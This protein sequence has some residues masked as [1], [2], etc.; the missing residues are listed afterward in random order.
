[1]YKIINSGVDF[2]LDVICLDDYNFL[3][4]FK[5]E[6]R[7]FYYKDQ[8]LSMMDHRIIVLILS[9]KLKLK[10]VGLDELYN[11]MLRL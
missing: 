5:I 4:N 6:N 1:M 11:Q 8:Q 9:V 2:K 10:L 7:K 3:N